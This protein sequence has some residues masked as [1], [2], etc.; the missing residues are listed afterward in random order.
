MAYGRSGPANSD[1][2]T[3]LD[4]LRIDE[5]GVS[6]TA[7]QPQERYLHTDHLGSIV[8]VTDNHGRILER[9]SYDAWGKRRQ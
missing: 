5:G 3:Y 7:A 8:A 6:I 9:S 2:L 4:N 1:S